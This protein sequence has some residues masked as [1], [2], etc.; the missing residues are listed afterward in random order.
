MKKT[1]LI[2]VCLASIALSGCTSLKRMTGQVDDTVLPGQR[3]TVIA[4]DQQTARDPVI[5]GGQ[6]LPGTQTS[7]SQSLSSDGGL[8]C[9]PAKDLCPA[10]AAP[11]PPLPPQKA[12]AQQSMSQQAMAPGKPLNGAGKVI[13][14]PGKTMVAAP[15]VK[16]GA[17]KMGGNPKAKLAL[18]PAAGTAAGGVEKIETAPPAT[19]VA[20]PPA[21]AGTT[22][23]AAPKSMMAAKKKMKKKPVAKMAPSA[24]ASGVA[25]AVP[26]VPAVPPAPPASPQ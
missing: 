25:P 7:T 24:P 5:T 19:V 23:V 10:V 2:S 18:P 11:P 1:F 20:T 6:P 12:I 15:P 21:K 9:D 17:V 16:M 26:A 4:S 22:A 3:E 13:V 8:A 14:A